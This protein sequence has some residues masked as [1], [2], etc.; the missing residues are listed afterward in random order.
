MLRAGPAAS[1][2]AI[3]CAM[4]NN[5]EAV[6]SVAAILLAIAVTYWEVTMRRPAAGVNEARRGDRSAYPASDALQ[7]PD[8]TVRAG[9]DR[10][11][12]MFAHGFAGL[13]RGEL[14]QKDR[15]AVAEP[16]RRLRH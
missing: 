12:Y 11:G 4:S 5:A 16:D 13:C 10:H 6:V 1:G 9:E 15:I 3:A 14:C 2:L 8:G 7:F